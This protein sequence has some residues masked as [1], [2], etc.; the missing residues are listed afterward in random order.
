MGLWG[1]VPAAGLG[2]RY[3]ASRPKQYELVAGRPV[4]GWSLNALLGVPGLAGVTVAISEDDHWYADVPESGDSR[5]AACIGGTTRQVSVRAA[6]GSLLANG[7]SVHDGVL[8]HDAARPGLTSELA[9]GLVDA[10]GDDI[11]GGLLALPVGDTVKRGGSDDR[12]EATLPRDALWA[13]QTPQ[14]FRIGP[15]CDALDRA[16]SEGV[17][18][19]DEASAM[20]MA[21]YCPLLVEGSRANLKMT[22]PADCRLL[23]ALLEAHHIDA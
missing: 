7:A 21:G 10:V 8:V 18:V 9:Q 2:S 14:L 19:T 11:N 16:Q 23:E 17:A 12:V 3:A 4:L 22:Y 1:V 15:L 13:A 20:E 6:L 5:V